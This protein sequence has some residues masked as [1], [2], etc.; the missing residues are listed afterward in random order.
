MNQMLSLDLPPLVAER[1]KALCANTGR[2][3]ASHLR[4]AIDWYFADL[5]EMKA[6]KE[7]LERIRTQ[8]QT[9]RALEDVAADFGPN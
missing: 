1:L 5:T 6:A 9:N 4:E 8:E 7:V 2:T 3:A